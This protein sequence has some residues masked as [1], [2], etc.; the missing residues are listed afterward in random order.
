M[1][2]VLLKGLNLPPDALLAQKRGKELRK[3]YRKE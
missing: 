3:A 2:G 1:E